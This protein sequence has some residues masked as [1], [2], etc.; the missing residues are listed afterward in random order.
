MAGLVAAVFTLTWIFS[1]LM[2]M[3]PYG[4]F[5]SRG[6]AAAERD[7]WLGADPGAAVAPQLAL[8]A[9]EAREAGAQ[10]LELERIR[11]DGQIWYR[12]QGTQRRWWVRADDASAMPAVESMLPD[13]LISGTLQ[14][15]RGIDHPP[16]SVTRIDRYDDVYYAKNPA[17]AEA[18]DTR[19]LPIWR[20]HWLDGTDLYA[21]A[22]AG[23]VLLR[24]DPSG[25]W[26]RLLYQGLHSLDFEPL[27]ARPW[28]REAL[29]LIL[30][31][32]GTALCITSCVIGWRALS[33]EASGRRNGAVLVPRL[34]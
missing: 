3:N 9:V 24:V 31:L 18:L 6:L 16:S 25:R 33:L 29:V 2:S 10:P 5:S 20:A 30:S 34:G 23:K 27:R 1:G 17:S 8:D 26:Q 12:I 19:P 11:I 4:V 21:D 28:L 7:R 13:V 32:L 14:R 22:T 15:L